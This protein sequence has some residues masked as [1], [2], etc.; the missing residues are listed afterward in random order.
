MREYD[1]LRMPPDVLNI[2]GGILSS[3]FVVEIT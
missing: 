3:S 2:G 1:E